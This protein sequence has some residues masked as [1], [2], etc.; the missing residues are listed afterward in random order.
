MIVLNLLPA[1][2]CHYLGQQRR[3]FC[4]VFSTG[5]ILGSGYIVHE[6]G[7]EAIDF[8]FIFEGADYSWLNL[9]LDVF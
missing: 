5:L 4:L 7:A 9:S 3:S 6:G 2:V 1:L 8:L